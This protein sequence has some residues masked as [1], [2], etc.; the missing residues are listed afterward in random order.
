MEP[1]LKLTEITKRF[2]GV[3]ATRDVS[4]EV[5]SGE[6]HGLL[7]ENGAGKTTLMNIIGG[8]IAPDSGQIAVRGKAVSLRSPLDS[9]RLG[10]GMV[11]Q[12][13]M[14]VPTM[15]VAENV[16]LSLDTGRT[17]FTN[18][19]K[20]GS[21]LLDVSER[22]GLAVDPT[23]PIEDLSVGE[24]QRVEIVRLLFIGAEILIFDEPT[25]VLT[26]GEWGEFAQVLARLSRERKAI[27]F[28]THK[29]DELFDVA[30]RCTVMRDGEVVGTVSLDQADAASLSQMMVGR[31][32]VLRVE[33]TDVEPGASVLSVE[34]L[35]VVD[36]RGRRLLSDIDFE[37]REGEIFGIAGVDGNGQEELV[38]AITGLIPL[39]EG[40]ISISGRSVGELTP[41]TFMTL[42]G[43]VIHA[44]RRER[45]LALDLSLEDNLMLGG[46]KEPRFNRR[47]WLRQAAIRR[48]CSR[49]VADYDIRVPGT[50]VRVRQL[51]GGNQQKAVLAREMDRQPKLLVAAQPTRG[52][53]VGAVEFVYERVLS[54]RQAGGATL[55][56]S[57]ELGEVLSLADRI[58][59]IFRGRLLRILDHQ[60]ATPEALGL[61]MAGQIDAAP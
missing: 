19:R 60:H 17:F 18:L 33:R 12:H 52:L 25:A 51:S 7:G 41:I 38:E 3:V 42:G 34:N 35:E 36:A 26:P 32:V 16:A 8:L 43:A 11:H 44:D 9:K 2:P 29:L 13:F 56:I 22:Y 28:I 30:D 4:L 55:L 40:R 47:G 5:Q 24:R 23:A 54:H 50:D 57:T 49:L 20:L 39:T 48:H 45:G 46:F 53:D 1:V 37:I 61:L 31:E 6:I 58:G 10:I 15:T 27:I 59:V 14:L 21:R